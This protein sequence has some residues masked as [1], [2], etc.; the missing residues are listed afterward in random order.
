MRAL[1]ETI[2]NKHKGNAMTTETKHTPGPWKV[3]DKTLSGAYQISDNKSGSLRICTVTNAPN[4]E[5]NARLIAAAP[6][7]LNAMKEASRFMLSGSTP[8]NLLWDA[9]TKAEGN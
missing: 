6:D 4:D 1:V 3:N 8:Y 7:M 5:A 2:R 9:I